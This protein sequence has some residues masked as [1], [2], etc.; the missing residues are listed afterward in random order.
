MSYFLGS[1]PSRW[2]KNISTYDSIELGEVWPGVRV[3]L[4]AR[5]RS[6]E[7]V[8][9]ILPGGSPETIRVAVNGADR[10]EVDSLG[11][12]IA[13]TRLGPVTFSPPVAYQRNAESRL[14][15]RAVYRVSGNR[16]GFRVGA[17]D[18]ALPLVIDPLLQ[19]TYLGGSGAER[20][21]ALVLDT[22]SGELV[23]AGFTNSVNFP[24]TVVGAQPLPS[25]GGDVFVARLNSTLTRLLHATYLGGD[26]NDQ[27]LSVALDRSTGEVLVAG[28]TSGGTFP[29]T[30]GGAQTTPGGEADAFVARL[31]PSLTTLLEASFLGGNGG[32]GAFG[33][34]VHPSTGEV[35]IAGG[36]RSTN[37]PG[38]AG[39]SQ[40]TL[41][42]NGG[43]DDA[44]VTRFDSTLRNV[45]Q[46]TY[47]GGGAEER[48]ETLRISVA[49]GD[50]LI[51]GNTFSND[52]PGAAGGAQ[53]DKG[54]SYD[55]F[56]ARFDPSLTSLRQATYLGGS[57]LDFATAIAVHPITG[58]VFVTGGAR[59]ADFPGTTGGAQETQ[60]S[61][62]DTGFVALL[63][64]TLTTLIQSTYLGGS[65]GANPYGAAV[66]A[67]S[68]DL[69]VTGFTGSEDF[70][71]TI[72]GAQSV[73]AGSG[74]GF[75]ARLDPRLRILRQATFV[76]GSGDDLP[77]AIATDALNGNVVIAGETSSA[78]F[79]GVSGSP[80]SVLAGSRDAFVA[81]FTDDLRGPEPPRSS[82]EVPTA[83]RNMLLLL[84]IALAAIGVL[85]SDRVG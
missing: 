21:T 40:Q 4:E 2:R 47:F 48:C 42:G 52:L 20:A 57:D 30:A 66:H 85:L 81:R 26:G 17:Y 68:G 59:S 63:N 51:G 67:G 28:V 83:S 44:F 39:G 75:V 36:T 8:F 24:G 35:F 53:S 50:V 55:G 37:L 32:D 13:Q 78:N 25:P 56:V 54:G 74:D 65:N 10:L 3:S 60:G 72:G 33:V 82:V 79:P 27:A 23:V 18:R 84:A 31:D 19:S 14:P 64:P 62:G 49:T 16:Y 7:K 80:Q 1:D 43:F 5:F 70:P 38:A 12:L 15:V 58:E 71:A 34:A 22:A 46:T 29:V 77:F 61:F 45:L 9:T 69:F 73:H 11:R 41:S 76:G 6:V